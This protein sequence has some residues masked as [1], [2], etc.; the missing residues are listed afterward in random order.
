MKWVLVV[1]S[2]DVDRE[3]LGRIIERLGYRLFTARSGE[4]ALH[5]MGQS[6]PNTLIMGEG[7]PDYDPIEL[8]RTIKEDRILS[9]PPMLLMTSNQDELFQQRARQAGFS[10]IVQRPMSIRKF[11]TS[12][13]MCLSNNRRLCIR[14]PMSFPVHVKRGPEKLALMTHNFGEG[15]MYIPTVEPLPGQSRVD[16]EFKLPGLRNEFNFQSKV[17]HTRDR[18]TDEL[19]AGMGLK[20]LDV[21]PAIETVLGIYMENFLVKRMAMTA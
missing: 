14:A 16:V 18:N 1:E 6:L 20:F 21:K 11:F 10:E 17:V 5:I 19:P 13:E 7:I 4:E 8:G 15:G 2:S 9:S 3:Y 12:L